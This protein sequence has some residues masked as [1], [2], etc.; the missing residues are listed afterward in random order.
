MDKLLDH[1]WRKCYVG[2]MSI[3]TFKASRKISRSHPDFR[4]VVKKG[5]TDKDLM[6][7][8]DGK[9]IILVK[10]IDYKSIIIDCN[11]NTGE[12]SIKF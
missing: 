6:R 11:K 8:C 7:S 3:I 5:D 1:F 10:D 9:I 4:G 12:F 2:D